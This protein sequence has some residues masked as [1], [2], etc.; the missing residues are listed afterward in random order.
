LKWLNTVATEFEKGGKL[1]E[2][3][4]AVVGGKATINE[5]GL[6]EMLGWTAGI[7]QAFYKNAYT[8]YKTK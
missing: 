2:K 8:M 4:D 7:F 1:Y 6:P 5:Y 3:Y